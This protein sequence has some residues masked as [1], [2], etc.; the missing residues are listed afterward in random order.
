MEQKAP[1]AEKPRIRDL[2]QP[3]KKAVSAGRHTEALRLDPADLAKTEPSAEKLPEELE[4]RA[5]EIAA[6]SF[7]LEK[8]LPIFDTDPLEDL[9]WSVANADKLVAEHRRVVIHGD[10]KEIEQVLRLALQL[11]QRIPGID[12][13][14]LSFTTFTPEGA[15]PSQTRFW[16]VGVTAPVR[17]ERAIP[18]DAASVLTSLK[19]LQ[20]E[21]P[22]PE[23]K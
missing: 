13:T 8:R 22:P 19:V 18:I 7:D 2:P 10:S 3:D 12:E 23:S 11:A 20:N 6:T 9:I 1:H 14:A 21:E 15:L 5:K 16:A 17:N 4:R